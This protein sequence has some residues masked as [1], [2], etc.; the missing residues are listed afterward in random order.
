MF[1]IVLIS[2]HQA[3]TVMWAWNPVSSVRQESTRELKAKNI[4]RTVKQERFQRRLR[5]PV[6][7]AIPVPSPQDSEMTSVSPAKL[8]SFRTLPD[9]R[10]ALRVPPDFTRTNREG[11]PVF[12]V[13][14]RKQRDHRLEKWAQTPL[15]NVCY[16]VVQARTHLPDY[17][18]RDKPHAIIVRRVTLLPRT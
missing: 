13:R 6:R 15:P 3:I 8:G 16:I 12:H 5:Q 9:R 17:Y 7:I 2:V 1:S 18:P 4:V 10:V 14:V 11:W